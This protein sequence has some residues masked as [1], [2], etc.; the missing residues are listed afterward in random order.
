MRLLINVL[1]LGVLLI[2]TN[3]GIAGGLDIGLFG[4][5]SK[6]Y[7]DEQFTRSIENWGFG[8]DKGFSVDLKIRYNLRNLPINIFN[9]IKYT[10]LKNQDEVMDV[11]YP[12]S[13]LLIMVNKKYSEYILS[14]NTGIEYLL[15]SK[16]KLSPY[17]ACNIGLNYFDKV[18]EVRNPPGSSDWGIFIDDLY[19]SRLRVG[20]GF[21]I[22][23]YLNITV[24]IKLDLLLDYDWLKLFGKEDLKIGDTIIPEDDFNV[25]SF[26]IGILYN[27]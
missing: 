25:L 10:G 6:I 16:S 8:L 26:S 2:F 27:L 9:T 21:S 19:S 17:I 7:M 5:Y 12:A 13:S 23:T 3:M 4:G 11:P 15:L 18:D 20:A 14:I 1:G 22:G 24:R